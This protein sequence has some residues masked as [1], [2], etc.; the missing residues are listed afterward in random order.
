MKTDSSHIFH[1]AASF[2][3]RHKY[4]ALIG[5][6]YSA[7]L[8]SL[9]MTGQ[10]TNTFD[11]LW[12]QNHFYS[13][14]TQLSSGRWLLIFIDK[15]VLGCHADPIASLA[16]LTL[17]VAGFLFVL[18]LFHITSRFWGSLSLVLFLAS[19][20]VAI[21][22]SYRFTSLGYAVA[23]LLA[24]LSVYALFSLRNTVAAIGIS[25]VLLGLSMACYQAYL[26]VFCVLAVFYILFLCHREQED[27]TIP[28]RLLRL[29]G[30]LCTAALFYIVSLTLFLKLYN[31]SLSSY[32]NIDQISAVSLLAALPRS[33]LKTYQYFFAYFFQNKLKLSTL[34]P[35]G[36]TI[37]LAVLLLGSLV[38]FA[39]KTKRSRLPLLLLA[40]AVLPMACNAYMLLDGG[41]K[42]EL[43]MTSGLAMLVP[44]AAITA[45]TCFEAIRPARIVSSALSLVLLYGSS[46][47]VWIDQQAM[48]EGQNACDTML[49]QVIHDLGREELLSPDYEYFFV[50]VPEEN[51]LFFTSDTYSRAN[52]YAQMGRFWVS[53]GCCQASYRGLINRR[54]GLALSVSH[55]SYESI[56]AIFDTDAMPSFPSDGYIAVLDDNIVVVKISQY[57]AYTGDSKYVID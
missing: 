53:G 4:P 16:A 48:Y 30:A 36:R 27:K 20:F 21:T 23:Y 52:A 10:F 15:L 22:L 29:I 8:Y 56:A 44:L 33:A 41:S 55:R 9:M 24:V 17:F 38:F 35:L 50:G 26:S 46:M 6:I 47:Q 54:M 13:G 43:Q 39:T 40:V 19:P 18:D 3:K 12:L 14:A 31:T 37:L 42:L 11:G 32:N 25:G 7:L 45:S 1:R 28:C 2:W 5:L 49:T 57:S 51:P 34:H